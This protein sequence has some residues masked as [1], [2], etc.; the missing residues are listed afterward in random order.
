MIKGDYGCLL[1]YE[2][3]A[4][5]NL[6]T[7]RVQSIKQEYQTHEQLVQEYGHI[8]EGIGT[9]KNFEVNLHIDE[10]VRP[11]AQPARRI[12]FHLRQKV[13]AALDKLEQQGIIEKVDGATP[14]ISPLVVIPKKDG[15]IR[16]CVDMRM[17]NRA[18]QRER[19]PTPT[20]DDLIHALNG[21]TVFSKL[22]L[23][24]GY[25]QLCLAKE[26]RHITT[27]ATH[28]GL[29][30]YKKLNF[31]TVWWKTRSAGVPECRSAGVPECRSAGVPECRSAGVPECRSVKL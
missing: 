9:L 26:S 25:H 1:S 28:E 30:R 14:W 17:A 8:F 23:R 7:L 6:I 5:L 27:F 24:S 29:R 16:L 11:V 3:A 13:S 18:I 2:T 15:D 22:D 4:A 12:P 19:H 20:V 10:S 21:A 31:G